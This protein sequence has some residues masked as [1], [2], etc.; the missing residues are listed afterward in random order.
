M[1]PHLELATRLHQCEHDPLSL[2][3]KYSDHRLL[4]AHGR[5]HAAPCVHRDLTYV[6]SRHSSDHKS[7]PVQIIVPA[8]QSAAAQLRVVAYTCPDAAGDALAAAVDRLFDGLAGLGALPP[9]HLSLDCGTAELARA[10]L[11]CVLEDRVR[12]RGDAQ[13]ELGLH[14]TSLT[15]DGIRAT[16]TMLELDNGTGVPLTTEQRAGLVM[17]GD[18]EEPQEAYLEALRQAALLS[19]AE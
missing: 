7:P 8:S 9:C 5:E 10:L 3:I 12:T 4:H 18:W 13:V 17:C 2:N 15:L 19:Q 6:L 16:P 1:L 11:H 14:A